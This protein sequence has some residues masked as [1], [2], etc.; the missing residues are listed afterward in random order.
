MENSQRILRSITSQIPSILPCISTHSQLV[1]TP[2][3]YISAKT[4]ISNPS[5]HRIQCEEPKPYIKLQIPK[6]SSQKSVKQVPTPQQAIVAEPQPTPSRIDPPQKRVKMNPIVQEV[7]VDTNT[8]VLGTKIPDLVRENKLDTA[9]IP[10]LKAYLKSK[11][12]KVSGKKSD[13]VARVLSLVV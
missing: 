8:S 4:L 7:I 3:S 9:T 6:K 12:Q 1:H 13:L 10:E 5:S 11:N 2:T